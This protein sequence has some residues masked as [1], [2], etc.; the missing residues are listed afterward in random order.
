MTPVSNKKKTTNKK[1]ENNSTYSNV[2]ATSTGTNFTKEDGQSL[3]TS[4]TES[5]ME[6]MKSQTAQQNKTIADLIANQLKRDAEYRNE[7]AEQRKA[8]TEAR[9][10]QAAERK[11]Q[12]AQFS[13][14]LTMFA[15]PSM[16]QGSQANSQQ[17]HHRRRRQPKTV[18][19]TRRSHKTEMN[20][21]K[22]SK[23]DIS[24]TS[25]SPKRSMDTDSFENTFDP[26]T[27]AENHR[28]DTFSR[29]PGTAERKH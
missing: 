7:Q 13:Q 9:H 22:P 1:S 21:E 10:E 4:L 24:N 17:R 19:Q 29:N 2:S 23:M 25:T 27:T 20:T 16:A 5:F 14:L 26:N 8:D 12:A 3:F 18:D 11:E 15:N 6:E 28:W